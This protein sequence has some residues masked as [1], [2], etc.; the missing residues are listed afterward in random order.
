MVQ[1]Q[2]ADQMVA[3]MCRFQMQALATD[4]QVIA[5]VNVSMQVTSMYET[6]SPTGQIRL[7][8]LVVSRDLYGNMK[9]G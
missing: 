3:K 8:L 5:V 9:S 4:E 2:S 6:I 7:L 1:P